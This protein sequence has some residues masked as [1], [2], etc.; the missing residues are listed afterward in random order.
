MR[1]PSE[2][3]RIIGK[4]YFSREDTLTRLPL[5]AAAAI[6]VGAC[7]SLL[8]SQPATAQDDRGSI[9][10]IVSGQASGPVDGAMVEVSGTGI[11]RFTEEDGSY[12]LDSVKAGSYEVRFS[13]NGYKQAVRQNVEV[14]A[15]D[16]TYL[17][18][19]LDEFCDYVPGDVNGDG[20][21]DCS[22]II[23]AVNLLCGRMDT[24]CRPR[25]CNCPPIRYPFY[26][27]GDVNGSCV[28]NGIDV[29]YMVMSCRNGFPAPGACPDCPPGGDL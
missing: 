8:L 23:C 21:A 28:F 12:V 2:C 19:L 9:A 20:Q 26:A 11:S 14:V 22:D 25:A 3:L 17:D 1:D 13:H 7:G 18:V 29:T 24:P 6:L 16:T 4:S 27:A 10:G 5:S 15:G